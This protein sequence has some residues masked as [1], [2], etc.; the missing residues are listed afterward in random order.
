MKTGHLGQ[1]VRMG[2]RAKLENNVKNYPKGETF[3]TIL[4][5]S[6]THMIVYTIVNIHVPC[7]LALWNMH[8][9]SALPYTGTVLQLLPW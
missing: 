9:N 5:T 7:I 4:L 8:E 1:I 2:K 3:E 6:L